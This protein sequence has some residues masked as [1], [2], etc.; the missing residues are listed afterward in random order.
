M[1]RSSP[2][3]PAAFFFSS[4]ARLRRAF[5][6]VE[7]LASISIVV[8]LAA[9]LFP[10]VGKVRAMGLRAKGIS[11]LRQVGLAVVNFAGENKGT[12]PGPGTTGYYPFYNHSGMNSNYKVVGQLAP[13]LGLPDPATMTGADMVTV[14]VLED[15]GFKEV[16]KDSSVAPNFVQNSVLSDQPGVAGKIRVFGN[17][18][19]SGVAATSPLTLFDVARMGGPSKIWMLTTTDQQLPSSLTNKSGWVSSLPATPAYGNVR[20][21]LYVD[22][23]VEAVP[24]DAPLP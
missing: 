2:W 24:L 13:Y 22:A 18:A 20:L 12:L 10:T 21:R 14:P 3:L 17:I 8:L 19:S 7:L 11:N 5:T 15:P 6:L 16:M 4:P 9:L 23:H 1:Q